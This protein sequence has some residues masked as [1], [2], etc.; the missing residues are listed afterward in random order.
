MINAE[1]VGVR[2]NMRL[3]NGEGRHA[4]VDVS[5]NTKSGCHIMMMHYNRRQRSMIQTGPF[6]F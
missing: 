1:I 5:Y 3:A 4:E 6:T 2:Q